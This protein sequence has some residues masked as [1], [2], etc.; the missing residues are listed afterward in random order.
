[1]NNNIQSLRDSLFETINDLKS[2]KIDIEKAKTISELSQVIINSTKVEVDF[3]KVVKGTG[4]GFFPVE[5]LEDT[6]REINEK[7]KKPLEIG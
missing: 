7:N 4:S 2:G 5:P 6:M 3:L 1:M